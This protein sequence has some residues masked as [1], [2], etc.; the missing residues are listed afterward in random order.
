MHE[1]EWAVIKAITS[2]NELQR[3]CINIDFC[4]HMLDHD[5]YDDFVFEHEHIRGFIAYLRGKMLKKGEALGTTQIH[6]YCRVQD[7]VDDKRYRFHSDDDEN[8]KSHLK[9]MNRK[10]HDSARHEH[11]D[12]GSEMD[13]DDDLPDLEDISDEW[14]DETDD[15]EESKVGAEDSG[16][17]DDDDDMPQLEDD[18]S[19][20][21]IPLLEDDDLD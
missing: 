19:D 10:P 20:G 2:I 11:E 5:H 18:S 16:H 7:E 13:G 17:D 3:L 14:E 21:E 9:V 12:S 4:Y 1:A 15:E 8:G 6:G